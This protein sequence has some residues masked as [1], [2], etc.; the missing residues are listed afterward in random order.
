MREHEHYD[1]PGNI[2]KHSPIISLENWEM[3]H[4]SNKTDNIQGEETKKNAIIRNEIEDITIDPIAI[5]K[6]RRR[7]LE[8][9]PH[10]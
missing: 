3:S 10:S 1:N 8:T 9:R 6:D 5:K 7:I 4:I 2:S